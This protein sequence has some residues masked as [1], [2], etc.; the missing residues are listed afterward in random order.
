MKNSK[1]IIKIQKAIQEFNTKHPNGC[2]MYS[3][4]E[5][6]KKGN[7]TDTGRVGV[8]GD[9]EIVDIMLDELKDVSKKY[10]DKDGF[11]NA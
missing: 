11:V 2:F 5:F 10:Q 3:F 7:C 8:Y 4:V 9:K 6:D 1:E